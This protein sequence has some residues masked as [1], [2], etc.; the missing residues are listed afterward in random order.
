MFRGK[1]DY[2]STNY[3][4]T[5]V[6]EQNSGST[7]NQLSVCPIDL[8]QVTPLYDKT[9]VM[10][11]A[12]SAQKIERVLRFTLPVGKTFNFREDDN[13]QKFSN[14]YLG[15]YQDSDGSVACNVGG[16]VQCIYS[17]L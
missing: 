10:S 4:A 3:P 12:F 6:F 2:T 14:L 15:I 7:G 11:N 5:E 17:D 16:H 1:Y 9:I 13:Q 8:D